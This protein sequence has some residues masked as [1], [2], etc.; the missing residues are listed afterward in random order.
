MLRK[1]WCDIYFLNARGSDLY[2]LCNCDH[3]MNDTDQAIS[4]S[5]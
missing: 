5:V 1:A 4:G 2:I 3:N